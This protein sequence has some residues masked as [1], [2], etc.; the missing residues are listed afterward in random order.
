MSNIK[1]TNNFVF[2]I[3]DASETTKNGMYLPS[4]GIE[5]QHKGKIV[6]V[7]GLVKDPK[8]KGGVGKTG[9]FH[10]GVG[11]EIFYE[12]VTYLV[13]SDSEIIGIV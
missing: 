7:G 2:I 1:A 8:I 9:I 11:F 12:E 3:R 6:S 13:L 5:K 10:A 4:K